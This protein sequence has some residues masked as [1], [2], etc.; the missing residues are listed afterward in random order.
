LPK[1]GEWGKI[2]TT[3]RAATGSVAGSGP[4]MRRYRRET[5]LASGGREAKPAGQGAGAS[6]PVQLR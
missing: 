5:F 4:R 6:V 3:W 2:F 1:T